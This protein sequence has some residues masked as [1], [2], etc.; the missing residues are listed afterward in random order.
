MPSIHM[1]LRT[2]YWTAM[3][4]RPTVR[5]M[6]KHL[7]PLFF[8]F[9]AAQ[10]WAGAMQ[11]VSAD[12]AQRAVSSGA[13]VLDVRRPQ[14]G[15]GL[16]PGSVVLPQDIAQRPLSELA[17]RLSAAG[18]DSSR[19]VVV[20]GEAGDENAQA[21]AQVLAQASAGRVL[22]LV[23]GVTEWQMRGHGLVHELAQRDAVPQVLTSF[24]TQPREPRMAG[25]RV[26]SGAILERVWAFSVAANT[27]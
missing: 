9:S 17:Q 20:V 7:L 12:E 26:R 8:L 14:Q 13:F 10:A 21:L 16:L 19:T 22:W 25:S 1:H 23:G 6:L 27:R 4:Q 5:A 24:A 2:L 15:A 3:G 18:V 11:P